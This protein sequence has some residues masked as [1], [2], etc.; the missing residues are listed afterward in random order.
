MNYMA[1]KG[2]NYNPVKGLDETLFA[3]VIQVFSTSDEVKRRFTQSFLNVYKLPLN[4]KTTEIDKIISK[5]MNL[6]DKVQYSIPYDTWS[7]NCTNILFDLIDEGLQIKNVPKFKLQ[8]WWLKDTSL[9]PAI[10][11][12]HNRKLLN[13]DAKVSLMNEE[14]GFHLF[15]SNSNN[16]FNSLVDKYFYI[17]ND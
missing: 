9:K 8:V 13:S 15:P 17:N 16:Y 10:M 5:A 6:S 11:A 7:S 2:I 3:S 4:L 14:F 1:P 12:F